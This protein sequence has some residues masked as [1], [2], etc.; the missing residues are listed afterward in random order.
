[1]RTIKFQTN[2]YYHIYNRGVDKR[3]VFCDEKDYLRFLR[4]MKD[5]N[6]TEPVGSLYLQNKLNSAKTS[7]VFERHRTSKI[8]DIVCY[9]LLPN[10]YHLLVKQASSNGI[11]EFMKRLGDGYTKY[12]NY[13]NKRTG[14]LFG[15]RYK[16]KP[17]TTD[18]QLIY[19][20]AYINGN[21][22]IHKICKAE[23]WPWSSYQE[24]LGVERGSTSFKEVEPLLAKDSILNQF[25]GISDYKDY[26]NQDINNS[27]EV[28]QAVKECL[29]D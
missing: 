9:A 3:E 8:V 24:H 22:E 11:S 6:Q 23:E 25:Q 26:I 19:T 1:M 13:R 4:S 2:N 20:S 14:S 15:G 7:D 18:E 27:I 16:A 10:H 17:I 29:I 12:F 21:P 28:K 5:F